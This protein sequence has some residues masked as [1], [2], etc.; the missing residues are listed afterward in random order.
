MPLIGI[1]GHRAGGGT[2]PPAAFY[3]TAA[4]EAAM[5]A[6]A[7]R[8]GQRVRRTDVGATF[9]QVASPASSIGN[10]VDLTSGGAGAGA[11]YHQHEQTAAAALWTVNHNLGRFASV[12]VTSPGGVA[13]W[14]D[15]VHLNQN[16]TQIIFS[17][18]ATGRAY[19]I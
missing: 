18:P 4:S 14:P 10:W 12:S 8:I 17:T 6:A 5:L 13:L 7:D 11:D 9:E 16:Q 3:S 1:R 15:V 19:F 2:A